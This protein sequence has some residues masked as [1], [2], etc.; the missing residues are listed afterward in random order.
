M[1]NLKYTFKW[2]IEWINL[3]MSM[4]KENLIVYVTD[5]WKQ[6]NQLIWALILYGRNHGWLYLFSRTAGDLGL[7]LD[8][9]V[10]IY[11]IQSLQARGGGGGGGGIGTP[12]FQFLETAVN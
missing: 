8:S 1:N 11:S 7:R 10:S 2:I 6:I 3:W 5:F 4:I 9:S 12:Q